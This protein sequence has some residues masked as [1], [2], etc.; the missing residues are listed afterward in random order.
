LKKLNGTYGKLK[1]FEGSSISLEEPFISGCSQNSFSKSLHLKGCSDARALELS[2]T[3][4]L[5][6]YLLWDVALNSTAA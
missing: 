5:V 4:V 3:A 1:I 6:E 2:Q